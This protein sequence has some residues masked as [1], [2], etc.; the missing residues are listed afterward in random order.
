MAK[1]SHVPPL[2]SKSKNF[3]KTSRFTS[4]AQSDFTRLESH[5]ESKRDTKGLSASSASAVQKSASSASAKD[6]A[7]TRFAMPRSKSPSF[8]HPRIQTPWENVRPPRDGT[9][10][11]QNEI[12]TEM[13]WYFNLPD[14]FPVRKP[15]GN[16]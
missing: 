15:K 12:T 3:A 13:E 14:Q 4:E 1:H 8:H 2:P 5:E 10:Y 7:P 6:V 16:H 9:W 11:R